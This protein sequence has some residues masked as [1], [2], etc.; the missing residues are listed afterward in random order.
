VTV[1]FGPSRS[2]RFGRALAEARSG[3]DECTELEPGRHRARFTLSTESA[4]YTA[5][6]PTP[7]R[8]PG[9]PPSSSSRSATANAASTTGSCR[10]VPSVRC[11]TPSGRSAT[12]WGRI[13][14][15]GRSRRLA[16]GIVSDGVE[17]IRN[18]SDDG[19][20]A[21][22]CRRKRVKVGGLGHS[23]CGKPMKRTSVVVDSPARICT[24]RR[25]PPW[26]CRCG[27]GVM[28]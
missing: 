2:K 4:A 17:R 21:V 16:F 28:R 5:L 10:A 7:R 13:R 25:V 1:E 26:V 11:S 18:Y 24:L 15:R 6:A 8:W 20:H 3:A 14:L 27:S 12:C 23:I 19:D 9:A 22:S